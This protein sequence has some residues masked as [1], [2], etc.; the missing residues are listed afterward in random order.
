M[1]LAL[2]AL[3]TIFALASFNTAQAADSNWKKKHPRRVE[4]NQR[5]RNLKN[6][7][8]S[9]EKS[10]KINGAQADRLEKQENSIRNQERADAAANGGHI[11]KGEQRELNR[12]ENNVN[13]ELNRDERRD[14]QKPVQA[15]PPANTH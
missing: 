1:K 10:G 8:E 12:E 3:V 7:T 11:T 6:R 15:A 4:V 9:A 5:D 14:A 2:S 13:R